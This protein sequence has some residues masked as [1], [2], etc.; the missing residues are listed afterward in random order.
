MP[1]ASCSVHTYPNLN[2]LEILM[3]KL[4]I[5]KQAQSGFTLIE[6]IV[7]IV[8]LG[9]LAAT[10]LP[11]FASL[12]GDA[13]FASLQAVKGSLGSTA[14][15]AHAKYLVNTTG[16]ALVSTV[17]EGKTITFTTTGAVGYP[18]ADAGF[19]AAAGIDT[20]DYTVQAGAGGGAGTGIPTTAA[21]EITVVPKGI[22]GTA[23]AEACYVKYAEPAANASPVITVAGSADLCK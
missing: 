7:V 17:V 5:N 22:A 20:A 2:T 15:M 9:I 14:A 10:A 6:L 11:K 3:N 12:G 8:I 23:T 18:Q 1:F 4:S 13:R 16:T 21:G 19:A